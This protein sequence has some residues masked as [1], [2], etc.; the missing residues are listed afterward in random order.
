MTETESTRIL[1]ASLSLSASLLE[2]TDDESI[3]RAA[4]RAGCEAL[5]ADGC[6]FMPFNEF[7]QRF[8]PLEFGRA[9]SF[10][11]ELLSQP[12]QRQKCK[13]CEKR[14]AGRECALLRSDSSANFIQCVPLRACGREAGLFSFIFSPEP[15]VD[16]SAERFLP[17]AMRLVELALDAQERGQLIRSLL[18]Q[19][20]SLADG[21]NAVAPAADRIARHSGRTHAAGARDPRRAG[22]N[23]GLPQN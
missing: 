10:D 5:G 9:P 6:L 12:A 16:E 7:S 11:A 18:V 15:R 17:E 2:A 21:G 4:M 20:S 8:S 1:Q 14:H 19:C 23:A 22:S 3:L 13:V